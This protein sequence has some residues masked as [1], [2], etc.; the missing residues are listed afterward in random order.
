MLSDQ[1]CMVTR[2]THLVLVL[3]LPVKGYQAVI[4]AAIHKQDLVKHL[5]WPQ[6]SVDLTLLGKQ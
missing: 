3:L 1:L 2:R 5:P 6:R 4:H